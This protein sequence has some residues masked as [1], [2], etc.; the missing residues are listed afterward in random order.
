MYAT[1]EPVRTS[2]MTNN[3]RDEVNWKEHGQVTE[4][5]C[6]IAPLGG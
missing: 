5:V 2:Q 6:I 3:I 1:N 4:V